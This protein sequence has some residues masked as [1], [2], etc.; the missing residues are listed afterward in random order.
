MEASTLVMNALAQIA[1][2]K[3]WIL[4]ATAVLAISAG[5]TLPA[6]TPAAN[7]AQQKKNEQVNQANRFTR[8]EAFD[9]DYVNRLAKDLSAQ[10]Y[11]ATPQVP[12]ALR[13]LSYDQYRAIRFKPNHAVWAEQ[14]LPYRMQMFMPGFYYKEPVEIATVDGGQAKHVRY[15]NNLFSVEAP[16]DPA[17]PTEDVGFAGLRLHTQL[18]NPNVWD[19]LAVFLGASYFRSL[20]RDQLFGIS[21]RGLALQTA[22]PKG[23]E[24]P[25][26]KAF[27]VEQP[28]KESNLITVHALLD[29]PSTTGAYVFLIRPG[30]ET[31]MDIKATL[32]PR[33]DLT[34][35]GLAPE[36]SMYMFGPNDRI[37]VD[38]YRPQ[39]HDSDGLLMINGRNERLWRPLSNPKQ[40]QISAFMDTSPMGFG[41]MQRDQQF[42]HYQ[43]MEAH[44]EKR[45]SLWVEPQGN[46]GQGAVLLVEI[47]TE[48]EV[49][50]NIV[51]FWRPKDPIPKGKPYSFAYRLT[52]GGGPLTKPGE[53]RVESTR[54][55]RA[56][57]SGATPKRLFVIDYGVPYA[58]TSLPSELPKPEVTASAGEVSN[59]TINKNSEGT[60]YRVAFELDPKSEPL[61]ELRVL[62]DFHGERAA[63]TW[64][65]R[66]TAE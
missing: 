4:S 41:L 36:T 62:L 19:E 57:I 27:W 43:D 54:I 5:A 12:A 8:N 24:F 52:W 35:V 22:S 63:E 58:G 40:L 3:K 38:D 50:D 53:V 6:A 42:S 31:V 17:L 11:K 23:E 1:H 13:D 30:D 34:E 59:V 7:G 56:S 48:S 44:Y 60:G 65:Y 28:S 45:P 21:A 16:A 55:G 66:W 61:V 49:N 37:G 25:V 39:V 46:W 15:A 26:F 29:S 14:D 33:V 20:G 32:Y 47:P 10:P 51:A 9:L 18:N 64:V 2:S